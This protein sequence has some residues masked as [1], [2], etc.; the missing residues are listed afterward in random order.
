[1]ET[2]FKATTQD[3]RWVV[4]VLTKDEVV[5]DCEVILDGQNVVEKRITTDRDVMCRWTIRQM[6]EVARRSAGQE[7]EKSDGVDS[8]GSRRHTGAEGDGPGDGG[9]D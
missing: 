2:F 3:G 5:F 7:Q 6:K 8:G 4:Q 9:A 1:M